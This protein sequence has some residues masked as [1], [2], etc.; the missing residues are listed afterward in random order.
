MFLQHFDSTHS[1]LILVCVFNLLPGSSEVLH[2]GSGAT[3]V[4][5]SD[6]PSGP[7]PLLDR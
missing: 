4:P 1:F 2:H 3:D 6:L 5:G 7:V